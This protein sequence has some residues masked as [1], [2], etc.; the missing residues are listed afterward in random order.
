MEICTFSTVK[1][2]IGKTTLSYNFG[3]YLAKQGKKVLF[4]DFDEQSSLSHIYGITDQEGT[5]ADILDID[6]TD[7][8]K[9]KIRNVNEN[10]DLISGST[11]LDT[12]QSRINDHS[13][14]NMLLFMWL[15]KY[16]DKFNL[17][18]YDYM[19]IDT[20]PDVQT[21][22]KNA[23]IVS[24][25]VLSPVIP[26][27]M[28]FDSITEFNTRV[29][30]LKKEAIDYNTGETFVTAKFYLLANEIKRNT[31]LSRE[32]VDTIKQ[33]E[34]GDKWIAVIPERELF[35]RSTSYKFSIAE[36]EELANTPVSQL[37]DKLREDPEFM[38][39]KK[40]VDQQKPEYFKEIND[41][42][43]KI[44]QKI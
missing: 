38:K 37:D 28:S 29:D 27:R 20:H 26:N 33:D 19:I 31:G 4:L 43:Q 39:I 21:A 14:K 3:E 10:I 36:M 1:G 15:S 32:L 44:A 5:A 18:Q 7:G 40:Y 25:A 30:N 17:D 9:V 24:D 11:R 34:T 16:F 35:N 42:F 23:I 22:T 2:G 6:N 41:V 8:S 12:I 13:N